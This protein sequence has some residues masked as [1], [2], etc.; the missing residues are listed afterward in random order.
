[1]MLSFRTALAALVLAHQEFTDPAS[2]SSGY[3]RKVIVITHEKAKLKS[4]NWQ[5]VLNQI[6]EQEIMLMWI[7]AGYDDRLTADLTTEENVDEFNAL[8]KAER[9]WRRFVEQLQVLCEQDDDERQ[10]VLGTMNVAL[11]VARGPTVNQTDSTATRS[12][13]R[14]GSKEVD[15]DQGIAI[16]IRFSKFTSKALPMSMKKVVASELGTGGSASQVVGGGIG[17]SSQFSNNGHPATLRPMPTTANAGIEADVNPFKKY[18]IMVPRQPPDQDDHPMQGDDGSEEIEYEEREVEEENLTKAY[19]FGK[20]W[21]P[22]PKGSF[23]DL[24]TEAGF[25][26]LGF[27]PNSGVS[28]WCIVS[29]E[30]IT[31]WC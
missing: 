13:F 21:V 8:P 7:G 3:K 30:S 26:V 23:E 12:V 25:D 20:T 24:K 29:V 2:K 4:N 9:F 28:R 14:M 27:M 6:Y 1:M 11:T 16:D 18:T 22:M 10:P 15:S 5:S 31:Q 19:K 17:T